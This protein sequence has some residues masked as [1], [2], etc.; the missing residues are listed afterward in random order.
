MEI[1]DALEMVDIEHDGRQRRPSR[2]SLLPVRGTLKKFPS[3]EEFAQTIKGAIANKLVLH[4]G[5]TIGHSHARAKLFDIGGLMDEIIRSRVE[6]SDNDVA[7]VRGG[8]QHDIEC[9]ARPCE[10]PCGAAQ[11]QSGT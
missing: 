5:H 8:H 7:I 4:G 9:P 6:S 2:S 10:L 3:I 1:V 11:L